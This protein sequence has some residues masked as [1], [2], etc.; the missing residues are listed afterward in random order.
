MSASSKSP[1]LLTFVLPVAAILTVQGCAEDRAEAPQS[2][3]ASVAPANT[4]FAAPKAKLPENYGPVGDKS[5]QVAQIYPGE[6]VGPSEVAQKDDNFVHYASASGQLV[7]YDRGGYQLNFVNANVTALCKAVLGDILALNYII[8]PKVAGQ[9]TLTSS[10]PI[11][12]SKLLPLL[13][14]AL[15]SIGASLVKEDNIYRVIP[16]AVPGGFQNVDT[17]ADSDGFGTT[18]I[19]AKYVPASTIANVLQGLDTRPG[20]VRADPSTNYV[21]VQGTAEE[22]KAAMEAASLIDVDWLKSKSVAIL[23]VSNSSPATV[24]SEVNR[25]LDTGQGGLSQDIVQLQPMARLNAVLAVS[26][27]RDALDQ[28]TKWVTRLDR[29][30]PNAG[31]KIYH[32]QY[33]KAKNVASLINSMFGSHQSLDK[34]NNDVLEPSAAG[35]TGGLSN[36]PGNNGAGGQP[37]VPALNV[38]GSADMNT[39]PSASQSPF[40]LLKTAF[41][42]PAKSSE[43][44]SSDLSTEGSG[45]SGVHAAADP[46]S[47]TVFIRSSTEKYRAIERAIEQMDRQPVQVDIEATIA[48]VTLNKEL[49]YGVQFFLK[50]HQIALGLPNSTGL[51]SVATNGLNL[52]VGSAANPKLLLNA[53]QNYTSVKIL[54]SPSLVVMDQQ[55]AVLQVGDQVP[56]LTQS[57]QSVLTSSAPIVSSVDY[58]DTGIILNVLPRV[59]SNGTVTL[60][61]EQEISSIANNNGTQSN[62]LTPTI[63]QRRIRSTVAVSNGQ[64]VMLAGL[65][66]Q[67]DN[68][69]VNGLPGISQIKFLR[70]ILSS[71][72]TTGQRDELVIFIKPQIIKNAA[73]AEQV[74]HEFRSRLLSMQPKFPS[75]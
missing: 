71:H 67:Q 30:D 16:G 64:T 31:V 14:T 15:S 70:D 11:E 41:R 20:S 23:P 39:G 50:N 32:L 61:V 72:D 69:N 21:M 34:A 29:V 47:N 54:S 42:L 22:R 73:D 35:P 3:F 60:D 19:V 18:V 5:T 45:G 25:I 51:A 12:K 17:T 49:Q 1:R 55:P 40:G 36:S 13:E 46:N 53:L 24:I 62:S 52:L 37:K 63:S 33:A 66:S 75:R 4:A 74:T 43:D 59:N 28:V 68:S 6:D 7:G 9:V 26:R 57:A 58:K 27:R 56:V 10:Q 38:D 48:E 65:I 8:D 44:D 2:L